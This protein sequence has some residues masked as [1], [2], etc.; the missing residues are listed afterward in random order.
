MREAWTR[1][2]A[3]VDWLGRG[4]VVGVLAVIVLATYGISWGYADADPQTSLLLSAIV[5]GVAF[6]GSCYVLA[7]LASPVPA[8][9]RSNDEVLRPLRAK[10]VLDDLSDL[11]AACEVLG[12]KMA[13]YI[14][15]KPPR[16]AG[17][18]S[19]HAR[20]AEEGFR[21]RFDHEVQRRADAA[22]H[23]SK[24][25]GDLFEIAKVLRVRGVSE[26]MEFSVRLVRQL[27]AASRAE[28][29]RLISLG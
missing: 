9:P 11:S 1:F 23:L 16:G 8:G 29:A 24:Q 26:D 25:T 2:W 6:L 21:I 17:M 12:Q 15:E 7:P 4:Q 13:D 14:A 18:R 20:D 28:R 22:W 27:A 5:G 10:A 19:R 3:T